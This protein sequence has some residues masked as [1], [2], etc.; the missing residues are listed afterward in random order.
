M[1]D[2]EIYR[3]VMRENLNV[4]KTSKELFAQIKESRRKQR[5]IEKEC[6]SLPE[7]KKS[8]VI[9]ISDKK[10][11]DAA[12]CYK[13]KKITVLNFANAFHPGG[14]C[15]MGAKAQEEYL[16]RCSTLYECLI[17]PKMVEGFYKKHSAK[18]GVGKSKYGSSD[19]IYTPNVKV[20]TTNDEL[21]DF[22][23]NKWF[24]INVIT[25]AAPNV[26]GFEYDKKKL[27]KIMEKRVKRIMQVAAKVDTDVLILGAFGCGVFA[28]PPK[29][30]ASIMI[31]LAKEY[32]NYFE[33][34]EF[35]VYDPGEEKPNL[36]AFINAYKKIILKKGKTDGR[37]E[38]KNIRRNERRRD[39]RSKR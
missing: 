21:T 2:V 28:N 36:T 17:D 35:A 15:I 10:T 3:N 16:C 19:I 25:C 8:G 31:N 37:S 39:R 24:D 27:R 9:L 26:S 6:V 14:G 18:A 34:I 29:M 30:V 5:L 7:A 32:K 38:S 12:S 22:D 1:A 33:T 13:G 4:C 20:I 11:L 23:K